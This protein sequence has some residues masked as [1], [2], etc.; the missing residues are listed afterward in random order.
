MTFPTPGMDAAGFGY[1]AGQPSLARLAHIRAVLAARLWL[2]ASPAR[3]QGRPWW[4]SERD[5]RQS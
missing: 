1:R 5:P 3:A 2:Q 4:H